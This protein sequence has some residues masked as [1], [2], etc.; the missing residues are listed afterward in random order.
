[1][2]YFLTVGTLLTAGLLVVSAYLEAQTTDAAARVSVTPTTAS[3]YI[4][5]ARPQPVSTIADAMPALA[6]PTPAPAKPGRKPK[7]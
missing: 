3:L 2:R 7:H 5:P 4:P 6:A 1:M